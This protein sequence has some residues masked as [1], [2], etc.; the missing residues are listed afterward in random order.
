MSHHTLSVIV[1]DKPGVLARVSAMFSNRGF[2]IHSLAVG[3]THVPGRSHITL[4]VDAPEL[5]QL[6]KQLHKLVNVIKVTELDRNDALESEVMIARVAC[7]PVNR[8]E[9]SDT[10]G[11]FG[12]RMIDLAPNSITFE[13]A[14]SPDQ[15]ASF[16]E[17]MRPYGIVDL[18]KSGRVAMKKLSEVPRAVVGQA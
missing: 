6:K 9:V 5:E 1:E 16:L 11:L 17:H 7:D 14:G 3:P 4:V 2:N 12:A 8:G 15:L 10:A 13:V 18:V